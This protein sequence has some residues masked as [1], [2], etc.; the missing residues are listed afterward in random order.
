M[1]KNGAER[2]LREI[3][4]F[5]RQP[6]D[7]QIKLLRKSELVI[8]E[9]DEMVF[10]AGDPPSGVYGIADGSIGAFI[11][12]P[13]VWTSPRYPPQIGRLVWLRSAVYG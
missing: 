8:I 10:N 4:W 9:P 7:F 13:I 2:L 1:H 5:S 12:S 3:G 6:P 11:P